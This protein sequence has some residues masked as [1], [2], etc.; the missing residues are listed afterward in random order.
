M[1]GIP[2]YLEPELRTHY[3]TN[4]GIG[5]NMCECFVANI[6]SEGRFNYLV[7]GDAFNLA[8]RLEGQSKNYGVGVVINEKTRKA[9]PEFVSLE[10]DLIAVKGKTEP[11]LN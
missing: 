8:A 6:G 3:A 2:G 11:V 9:A 1:A 10:L 7:L 4:V 5:L